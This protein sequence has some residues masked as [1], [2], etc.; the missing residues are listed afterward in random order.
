MHFGVVEFGFE[1]PELV[2]GTVHQGVKVYSSLVHE[3]T[4]R[5]H[6]CKNNPRDISIFSNPM[7]FPDSVAGS[8]A[9]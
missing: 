6:M 2:S 9:T 8:L 7:S 1:I 3:T 4:S 5:N